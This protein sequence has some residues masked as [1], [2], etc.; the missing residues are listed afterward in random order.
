[1]SSR[2]KILGAINKNKPSLTAKVDLSQFM[3][4]SSEQ[5]IV[6]H[7]CANVLKNEGSIILPANENDLSQILANEISGKTF[8]DYT[9][10]VATDIGRID[11]KPIGD[12]KSFRHV[13][14]LIIP[15]PLGV[16]ENAAIWWD[17]TTVSGNRILPFI[18]EQTIVLINRKNIVPTMHH[19]YQQLGNIQSGF[20]CFLAGPSK[21]GDIEQTLVTGAQGALSHLV[22][23]M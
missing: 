23:L 8:I 3:T 5:E 7:F 15:A 11:P 16:A 2:S 20:G 6:D 4:T 14:I 9:G 12:P 19:A 21:T 1:M 17:D 22:L 18:V 10:I 13:H